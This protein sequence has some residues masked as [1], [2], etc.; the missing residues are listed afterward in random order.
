MTGGPDHD[1]KKAPNYF[2][3]PMFGLSRA[4]SELAPT[5]MAVA[6]SAAKDAHD[7]AEVLPLAVARAVAPNL[8]MA[9]VSVHPLGKSSD[10]VR[11]FLMSDFGC[12]YA[13]GYLYVICLHSTNML[14]TR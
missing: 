6:K 10:G 11:S 1:L 8:D 3:Q 2:R 5:A 4:V 7:D 13:M 12:H 14:H 9:Y